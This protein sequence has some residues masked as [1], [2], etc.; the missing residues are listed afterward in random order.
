[1]SDRRQLFTPEVLCSAENQ[2][3]CIEKMKAASKY[4]TLKR[5]REL[6]KYAAV[7]VPLVPSDKNS[8]ELSVLYTLRS[9]KMRRHIRQVSFPGKNTPLASK[10]N[11]VKKH[12]I[13]YRFKCHLCDDCQCQFSGGIRDES[14]ASFADCALRETEEEIGIKASQVSVWGETNLFVS[15][16]I[17]PP[18]CICGKLTLFIPTVLGFVQS[19]A[20]LLCMSNR[21]SHFSDSL[22][23][24]C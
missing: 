16:P 20:Q 14:D 3:K 18:K 10:N 19:V 11:T 15:Q 9:N 5:T 8:D 2:I 23:I 21:Y 17:F 6:T 12:K 24:I 1:M 4:T 22:F 7:L 13:E